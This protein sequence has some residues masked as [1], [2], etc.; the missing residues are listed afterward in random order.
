[1]IRS[2]CGEETDQFKIGTCSLRWPYIIAIISVFQI[3]FLTIL[4]F[5]LAARQA[6]FILMYASKDRFDSIGKFFKIFNLS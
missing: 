6:K 2:V 4:S 1:V 3:F 5:L